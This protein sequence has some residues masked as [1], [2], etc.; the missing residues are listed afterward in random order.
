MACRAVTRYTPRLMNRVLGALVALAVV[1]GAWQWWQ[2]RPI[3]YRPGVRVAPEVP[4]QTAAAPLEV[5]EVEGFRLTRLAHYAL[6]A[7]VLS[8]KRYLMDDES[9][10][11]PVDLALGWGVMSDD[12][13]LE[14]L[15]IS[16]DFRYY[17]YQ[18]EGSPPA[19]PTEI[20]RSSANCH[21]IPA[22]PEVKSAVLALP[23]GALVRLEGDLVSARGPRGE[24]WTSSL[25]RNDTGKGA[26][27]VIYLRKVERLEWQ[28]P[29]SKPAK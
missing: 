7:R 8:R 11:S 10:L 18:W 26:C 24:T 20:A 9:K 4:A 25:T 1:W 3:R 22:T 15:S 21:I 5:A 14:Q 28:E 2:L 27:E 29:S 12:A 23:P 13:V 6:T 17:H 16:Q 19:P